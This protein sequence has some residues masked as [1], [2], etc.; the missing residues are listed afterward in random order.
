MSVNQDELQHR[1][2]QLQGEVGQLQQQLQ[3]AQQQNL[4]LQQDPA[5]IFQRHLQEDRQLKKR[6]WRLKITKQECEKIIK[7]DGTEPEAVRAWIKDINLVQAPDNEALISIV[8]GT[9]CGAFRR[10]LERFLGM[11]DG[12]RDQG[13]YARKYL[14]SLLSALS[15]LRTQQ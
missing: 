4:Q 10:E 2:L 8:S 1:V 14:S 12:G 15:C 13:P 3:Q 7:C 5:Q 9:T 11:Q 6:N